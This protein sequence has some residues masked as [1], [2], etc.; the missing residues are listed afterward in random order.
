M[1]SVIRRV[2]SGRSGQRANDSFRA[3][4]FLLRQPT[5]AV[6]AS[7]GGPCMLLSPTPRSLAGLVVMTTAGTLQSE[8]EPSA[9]VPLAV[10][11]VMLVA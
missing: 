11:R 4:L 2:W 10:W 6:C 5:S 3:T 9:A 7:S 8:A 1:I